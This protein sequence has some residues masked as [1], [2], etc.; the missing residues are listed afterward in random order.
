MSK[1]QKIQ[2]PCMAKSRN[3][4]KAGRKNAKKQWASKSNN[5]NDFDASSAGDDDEYQPSIKRRRKFQNQ[6]SM[7]W[8][9]M[10]VLESIFSKYCTCRA[11]NIGTLNIDITQYI[12]NT[13]IKI[14][15]I[16]RETANKD[17]AKILVEDA[18][19]TM[20]NHCL[21]SHDGCEEEGK[22]CREEPV[23]RTYGDKFTQSDLDELLVDIFDKWLLSDTVYKKLEK[24]GNTSN[25]ESFHSIFTNR[26]LWSKV[27]SL[28]TATPK[29]DGITAV[30]S[31]FYNFGDR[32]TARKMMNLVGWTV[33]EGNLNALDKAERNRD[34]RAAAKITAKAKT[35][36]D[37]I[38]SQKQYQ[39]NTKWR[40]LNPYIPSSESTRNLV[41]SF[42]SK[43]N[44]NAK[45]KTEKPT[46]SRKKCKK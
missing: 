4:I 28:H 38:K 11:C 36:L 35:K 44:Q 23:F 40:N 19:L 21:G 37:R 25:L 3:R 1:F 6:R 9:E 17:D 24:S 39:N 13:M 7:C 27:G 20:K 30:A 32:E 26:N 41:D 46:K 15:K 31:T 12:K 42:N 14:T 10:G 29:F 43:P 45:S 22:N 16:H 5:E 34:K 2:K 18:W 33:L 8:T